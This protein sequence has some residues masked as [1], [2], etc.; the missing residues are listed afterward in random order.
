MMAGAQSLSALST[1]AR[2]RFKHSAMTILVSIAFDVR[3][4]DLTASPH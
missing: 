2:N 3:D 1:G 4:I